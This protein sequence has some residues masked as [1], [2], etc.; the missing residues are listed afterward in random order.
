MLQAETK[1]SSVSLPAAMSIMGSV[2]SFFFV[3]NFP[4]FAV[5]SCNGFDVFCW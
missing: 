4:L 1:N 3:Y 5:W 2:S